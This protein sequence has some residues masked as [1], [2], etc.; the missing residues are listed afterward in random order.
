MMAQLRDRQTPNPDVYRLME[1]LTRF[2]E[3]WRQ[4]TGDEEF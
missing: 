2:C 3:A 4:Q 1:A